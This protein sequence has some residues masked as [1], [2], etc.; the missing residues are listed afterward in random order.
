MEI[1][2][3]LKVFNMNQDKINALYKAASS[4]Y[5]NIG[6]LGTFTTKLQNPEKRKLLYD[7]MLKDGYSNLGTY[8]EFNR[9]IGVEDVQSPGVSAE[10]KTDAGKKKG[11][12]DTSLGDSL[13]NIGSGVYGLAGSV[14]GLLDKGAQAIESALP[15]FMIRKDSAGKPIRN[16]DRYARDNKY[17]AENLAEKGDAYDG[18]GSIELFQEGRYLASANKASNEAFKSLPQSVVAIAATMAGHPYIGMGLIG[19]TTAND[20][21]DQLSTDPKTKDMPEHLKIANSIITGAAE[22]TSE[23]LGGAVMS[24]MLKR[25]FK[26]GGRAAVQKEVKNTLLRNIG[27][28]SKKYDIA[29]A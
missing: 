11:F 26:E 14:Y 16:F 10:N 20:K 3:Q 13:E 22:G 1:N 9:K 29:L 24:G 27:E 23:M 19:A 21:Y 25:A 7:T 4:R 6:D 5:S 17:I 12:W 28:L 8:D 15:D 2:L 18:K